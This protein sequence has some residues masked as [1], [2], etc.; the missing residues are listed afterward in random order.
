MSSLPVEHARVAEG[1]RFDR[2]PIDYVARVNERCGDQLGGEVLLG[3]AC[4]CPPGSM[5]YKQYSGRSR[6]GPLVGALASKL[7]KPDS[8]T[9]AARIPTSLGVLAFTEQ[10]ILW[11]DCKGGLKGQ[12]PTKLSASWPRLD[13]ELHY[14]PGGKGY[15]W[16]DLTFP[17]GS[18]VVVFSDT[19][20]GAHQ[21]A[22][23]WAQTA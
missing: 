9:E 1:H 8:S 3:A 19:G 23:A 5:L 20:W 16:F 2:M 15:P 18:G 13:V 11:F 21:F 10:R 22:G 6:S 7:H 4:C 17:D 14:D 12:M